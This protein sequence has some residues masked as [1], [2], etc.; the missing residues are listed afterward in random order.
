VLPALEESSVS[1]IVAD[2]PYHRVKDEEW[3]RRWKTDADYLAWIG[4]LCEELRRVLR[5][6]GSLYLF[7]SPYMA[8]RVECK[9]GET[10]E[11]LNRITWRKPL[12]GTKAEMNA[13]E[14]QRAYF[15]ISEAIIFAEHFGA[16]SRARGE[17]GWDAKCDEL[18]SF[19][20]EPLRAYLDGERRRAGVDK[21][22]CNVA[23]GFS[24]APGG[25]ASRKYFSPSQ[26]CL[27]TAEHYAALQRLF[28]AR[29]GDYLRREYDY[30]RREYEDLRREYEDLRREYEDLRREYEDLRRPFSVSA[31]VPYTDVWDFPTV[32]AS[33]SKHPCQKP[34]G[35]LEHIVSASSRPGD[36]VLDP[37]AGSG[38]TGHACAALGRRCLLIEE[39][40]HWCRVIEA[41]ERRPGL[42]IRRP[43]RREEIL[44][45]F[46]HLPLEAS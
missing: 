2:P 15:P 17:S 33:P 32:P 31:D 25:M 11:V 10:F 16:D 29:G 3:D 37:F 8:A 38:V 18:R 1:L 21:I 36:L 42:V 44:P 39:N 6:N 43:S 40:P 4:R 34:Q 23:C 46:D 30:L 14:D 28:N 9:I 5:P 22:Q 20:F 45:L 7:A 35:L 27:P 19:V 26:W 13:K 24:E 41:A 12:F